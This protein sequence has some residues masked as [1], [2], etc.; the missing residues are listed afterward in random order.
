MKKYILAV[1]QGTTS[2]RAIIFD[3]EGNI[4]HTAQK[5]L[6]NL[7]PQAGWVEQDANELWF[8]T[9][10]VISSVVTN[11]N[12]NPEEIDCIGITNQRETTII[13]DKKTGLPIYNAIV[14]QSRQ[15]SGIVDDL[16]NQ[17]YSDLFYRK[18]GLKMDAYFSA[19]KIKWLLD[20]IDTQG[21]ELMFGTVDTWLLYNLSKNKVHA[22]DYTNAS[23]TMLFNI[24][25]LEWDQELLD[26]LDIPA[27]ILPEVKDS[28]YIF[29][30]T[31]PNHFF[32]LEIPIASLAGDQQAALFGQGCLQPGMMKNTYGT[33]CFMLMNTGKQPVQSSNGLLSTIAYAINN[34]VY[35]ALEGSVFVAGSAVQW[36]RDSLEFI[37][38]AQDIN[39]VASDDNDGVYVVPAFVGLGSPYWDQDVKGAI[40]GL[41]RGSTK[42]NIVR[43]TLESIA[44]QTKDVVDLI[45]DE[46]HTKLSLLRVD[47]G[48]S[49]NDKLMQFQ[50]DILN[51]PVEV[52][53][54]HEVTA[55]GAAYLA[56]LATG[57]YQD[58]N[59]L[60]GNNSSKTFYPSMSLEERNIK[61]SKWQKAV[62]ASM[63]FK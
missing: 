59:N 40:F 37:D 26:I 16:I 22:S 33:G 54:N 14:W 9:L 41:T 52:S 11:A 10:S 60:P 8:S 39:Q 18:T 31:N 15:S 25:T 61:Y 56:G 53:K 19:T 5:E 17:G 46:S 23:R 27:S 55:L 6:N 28:S 42:A 50:A 7:F 21:K 2:S 49:V 1:D 45:I 51:T 32:G 30:V 36:L 48:A 34:Q 24:H 63:V 35:Y 43:A 4:L 47:G 58:I 44:Y 29:D 57:F 62:Q 13:W 38:S 20:N 12:I 3:K